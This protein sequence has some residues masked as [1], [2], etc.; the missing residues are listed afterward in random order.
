IFAALGMILALGLA[1]RARHRAARAGAAALL[2]LLLASFYFTY[3][4]TGWLALAAGVV[5]LVA[6][7]RRRLQLLVL[8]VALLPVLA[9]T[10]AFSTHSP[11]LTQ[12]F[13]PLAEATHDGHRLTV[14]LLVLAALAAAISFGLAVVE[15]RLRVSL[16]T[17]R[18]FAASV[19]ACTIVGVFA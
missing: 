19:A 16:R 14:L 2:P 5:A 9:A 4:R 1:A 10:L 6:V 11:G 18:I 13:S 8:L 3:G 12:R 7:D 17:R 15:Q